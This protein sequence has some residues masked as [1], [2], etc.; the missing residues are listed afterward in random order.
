[1]TVAINNVFKRNSLWHLFPNKRPF[2]PEDWDSFEWPL[3]MCR[4]SL[5]QSDHQIAE[6]LFAADILSQ[7][8]PY[9]AAQ[10]YLHAMQQRDAEIHVVTSRTPDQR[11]ITIKSVQHWYPFIPKQN[12]H[13]RTDVAENGR[14]F[15]IQTAK[16][17]GATAYFDDDP[18]VIQLAKKQLPPEV[19]IYLLAQT[20][21]KS[22]IELAE[23][24][25]SWLNLLL[26]LQ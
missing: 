6:W 21:N 1:M 10:L 19:A 23:N 26:N 17:L 7:G 15:K 18:S 16:K 20:W 12:I 25:L 22:S 2:L 3:L 4:D 24:R 9:L 5:K 14:E 8:P 11:D 13:L